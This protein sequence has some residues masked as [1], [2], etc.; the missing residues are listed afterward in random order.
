MQLFNQDAL[1]SILP[2]REPMLLVEEVRMEGDTAFG[3]YRVR[4][5]EWF[6]RGHFPGHP[7][8]PGVIL[9]EMMAQTAC[10][11]LADIAAGKTPFFTGFDKIRFKNPVE[12]GQ[13]FESEC[14]IIKNKGPVY[15][16]EGVGTVGGKVCV[17]GIF[18]FALMEPALD[19]K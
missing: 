2:H 15:F 19:S 6:L 16:A 10:V 17:K 13:V 14:R 3:R 8:V 1:K 11:L 9:C 18:S 7:V 5:D 4:G 12:P